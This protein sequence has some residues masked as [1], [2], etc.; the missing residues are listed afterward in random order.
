MTDFDQKKN[1]FI[2]KGLYNDQESKAR[3]AKNIYLTSY[4]I[5]FTGSVL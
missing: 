5:V 3:D 2:W 4:F 1:L